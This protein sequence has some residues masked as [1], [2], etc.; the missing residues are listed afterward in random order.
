MLRQGNRAAKLFELHV[1][2]VKINEGFRGGGREMAQ[3]L[4]ALAFKRADPSSLPQQPHKARQ[5][6]SCLSVSLWE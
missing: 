6:G 2:A 5:S 3:H 1:R 4:K